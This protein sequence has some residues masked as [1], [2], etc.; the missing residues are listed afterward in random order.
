M[1]EFNI[2]KTSFLENIKIYNLTKHGYII[3]DWAEITESN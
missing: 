2:K 1:F 3:L